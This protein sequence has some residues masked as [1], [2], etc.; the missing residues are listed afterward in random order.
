V[1]AIGEILHILQE[2]ICALTPAQQFV[3]ASV[4]TDCMPRSQAAAKAGSTV[5]ASR[6]RFR[7]ARQALA[8][9]LRHIERPI[10]NVAPWEVESFFLKK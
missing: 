3:V 4:F 1:H 8:D 6:S 9:K 7:R 5:E 10:P 2:A